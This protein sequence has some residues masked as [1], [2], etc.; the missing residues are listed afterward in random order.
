MHARR[1]MRLLRTTM[2]RDICF[3]T[4]SGG[5]A[6][7]VCQAL[8]AQGAG[9]RQPDGRRHWFDWRRS[10]A[11]SSFTGLYL[12]G[13]CSRIYALYP[14]VAQRLLGRAPTPR[15]E[16]ALSTVL[17]NFLHVPFVYMPTFYL[18]T[19]LIRGEDFAS[20][21]TTL[22]AHWRESVAAC[23]VCWLP[24]QF[25]IFSVVPVGARVRCVA[26]GDFVWNILLSFMAHR[27]HAV[28]ETEAEPRGG[29][30]RMARTGP[31]RLNLA[32]QPPDSDAISSAAD[33]A[34]GRAVGASD[35]D[36]CASRPTAD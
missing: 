27:S 30:L 16:G 24:T 33:H 31:V 23:M 9:C 34:A 20:A 3:G 11:F 12:G 26:A 21:L 8:E 10:L 28:Q 7:A 25:L 19:A 5:A 14:R 22:R 15:E 13:C 2:M 1:D 29:R 35:A 36:C 18:S 32:P 6:D 17:D 4:V